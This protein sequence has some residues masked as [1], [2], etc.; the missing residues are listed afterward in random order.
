LTAYASIIQTMRRRSPS[1]MQDGRSTTTS[2]SIA[3][4]GG[5]H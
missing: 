3:C 4:V 2:L 1:V 5:E